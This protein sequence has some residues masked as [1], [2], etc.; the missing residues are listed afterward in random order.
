MVASHNEGT[1]RHTLNRML[2]LQV[3]PSAGR[4]YFG[5]LLGMCDHISFALGEAGYPVYKYVP[6]GP[7]REVLPYLSRR[8]QENRSVLR[9]GGGAALERSLVAR[10]LRRRLLAPLLSLVGA[11]GGG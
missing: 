8:A 1:V 10:E 6:Y 5:Q 7:V 4:V 2:E 11:G 3:S 9:G